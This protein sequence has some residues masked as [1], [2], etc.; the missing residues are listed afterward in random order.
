[1]TMLHG[2]ELLTM[3]QQRTL[4]KA[5]RCYANRYDNTYFV[6]TFREN[7]RWR[8][9]IIEERHWYKRRNRDEETILYIYHPGAARG[10]WT[11]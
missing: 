1:M 5:A 4:A 10:Q 7:G 6:V 3:T 9:E 8:A 11:Y 2:H